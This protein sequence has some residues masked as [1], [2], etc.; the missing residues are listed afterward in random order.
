MI[1]ARTAVTTRCLN[2]LISRLN[3]RYTEREEMWRRRWPP[4]HTEFTPSALLL[5]ARRLE[6][7]LMKRLAGSVFVLVLCVG[8]IACGG[9]ERRA[10][11][12]AATPR[13]K[14]LTI[15]GSDTMVILGQRLAEEYM[16]VNPGTV[17]QVNGGGSGTGIAALINGTA[18]L[19][20]S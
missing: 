11:E 13:S 7:A 1:D 14:P 12:T 17:V 5:D 20:Q 19:A 10:G 18:D 9:G 4:L 8:L 6:S 15:K 2:M 3:Q 16:K